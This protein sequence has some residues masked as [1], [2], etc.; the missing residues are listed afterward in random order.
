[1]QRVA[2][3]VAGGAV[4]IDLAGRFMPRDVERF[5]RIAAA[6][7]VVAVWLPRP[8]LDSSA[9]RSAWIRLANRCAGVWGARLLVVEM[10]KG[11][12]GRHAATLLPAL[13]NHVP[14]AIAAPV[15]IAV[16]LRAAHLEGGRPH[17]VQLRAL[18]RF[19]E[20]WDLSIALDLAGALDQ[21]WEAEAAMARL[22]DH[23]ALVRV[24]SD[25]L[26]PSPIGK[27]RVAM[28][29]LFAGIDLQPGIAIAVAA[30]VQ[31]WKLASASAVG[32]SYAGAVTRFQ[33]RLRR[34]REQD[35][36]QHRTERPR[37]ERSVPPM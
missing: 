13:G 14:G 34:Q 28:R 3:S 36:Y 6:S 11:D 5:D 18:R 33:D 1:M 8:P 25:A 26:E 9:D 23:T 17:L 19:A 21:R 10:P 16:G 31:P 7:P 37:N 24:S 32:S 20:E 27:A 12:I 15:R 22:A 4:E 29:A 30:R 2:A 35:N